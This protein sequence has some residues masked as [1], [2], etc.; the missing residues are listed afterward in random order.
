M[1][2]D[3][4]IQQLNKQD[5]IAYLHQLQILAREKY[6]FD[7]FIKNRLSQINEFEKNTDNEDIYDTT[8]SEQ[9]LK[10]YNEEDDIYNS[11]DLLCGSGKGLW[12]E[13]AQVYINKSREDDRQF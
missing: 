5:F 12:G 7:I 9:F 13:D 6:S 3:P 8:F 11:I 2:I 10:G 4:Q 1:T